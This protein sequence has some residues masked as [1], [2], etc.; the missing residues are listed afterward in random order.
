MVTITVDKDANMKTFQ[1][2]RGLLCFHSEY[3]KNLFEGRFREAQSDTHEMP[4]TAVSTFHMF[5][6]WVCTGTISDI[7]GA[8]DSGIGA[9]PIISLYAFADYHVIEELKN[10]AAELFFIRTAEVWRCCFTGTPGLYDRTAEGSPLRRLHVD[11]LLEIYDFQEMRAMLPDL[12]LEFIADVF[13]TAKAR[14]LVCGR[15]SFRTR[16]SWY[17]DKK[18]SF[19]KKYHEHTNIQAKS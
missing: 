10:R 9:E 18:K 14:G 7:D 11:N 15:P 19:C 5:Y 6:S 16:P 13:E 1:M 12:P 4:E 17:E 2:Y 8:C 3:F